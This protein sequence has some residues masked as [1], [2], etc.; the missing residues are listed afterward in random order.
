VSI[1]DALSRYPTG[2]ALKVAVLVY[3]ALLLRLVAVPLAV[4]ALLTGRLVAFVDAKLTPRPPANP[5]PP[6]WA[7]ANT[8]TR[9]YTT[10]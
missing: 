4:A 1:H 7:A 8:R 3:L 6:R 9:A 10:V 2:L 5:M